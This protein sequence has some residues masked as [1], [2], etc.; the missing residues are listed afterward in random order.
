LNADAK[1]AQDGLDYAKAMLSA[2]AA[3]EAKNYTE[4]V[5]FCDQALLIRNNDRLAPVWRKQAQEKLTA[6]VPPQTN[7]PPVAGQSRP[8]LIVAGLAFAWVPEL[9]VPSG[10]GGYVSKYEVTQAQYKNIVGGLPGTQPTVAD[11]LPV[12]VSSAAEANRFCQALAANPELA[13]KLKAENRDLASC[14]LP[15]VDQYLFLVRTEGRG[16]RVALEKGDLD[17]NTT[18]VTATAFARLK[19]KDASDLEGENTGL[20]N[21]DV[22]AATV[23]LANQYHLSNLLGNALE[24]TAEGQWFGLSHQTVGI[25]SGRVLVKPAPP[26]RPGRLVVGL[27]PVLIISP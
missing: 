2:Q 23:G 11:D 13:G 24:W 4:V 21:N 27:R 15:G 10:K 8:D 25:A 26:T 3:L 12:D 19:L 22:R 1:G 20:P 18:T 17:S 16:T 5:A 14:R 9:P 6:V 7:Q